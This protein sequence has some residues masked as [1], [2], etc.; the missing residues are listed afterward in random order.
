K[1]VQWLD[2]AGDRWWP[3]AGG[4]YY[5]HAVKRVANVRLIRP[6]WSEKTR[7]RR[8]AVAAHFTHNTQNHTHDH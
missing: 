8:A 1:R 6:E 2:S 3:I 5:L 7:R 4:T